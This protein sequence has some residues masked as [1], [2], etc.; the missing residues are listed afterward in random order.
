V[1]IRSADYAGSFA[2][3]DDCPATTLPE[4]AFVGRSNVGKSSFINMLV[5][6]K[7][8]VK[9]SNTPGKTKS[10]NFFLVNGAFH[11]V[12]LPGYGFAKVSQQTRKFFE[13]MIFD[14]LEKRV[15]LQCVFVLLDSRLPPQPPDVDFINRLGE[16][17]VPLIL[18]FTKAD[19]QGSS[20]T[21]KNIAQLK[22]ELMKYWEVLPPCIITSSVTRMGK[23][24]TLQVIQRTME[25]IPANQ[26]P[27]KS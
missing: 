25:T 14:Y 26:P 11:L 3:V 9:V 27:L 1:N 21:S 6:R 7:G 2:R 4:F 17:Q 24:E 16:K 10:I 15:P 13:K 5:N 23:E 18:L 8:L 22:K 19:K 12:D 20:L